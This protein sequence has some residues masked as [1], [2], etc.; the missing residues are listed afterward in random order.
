MTLEPQILHFKLTFGK[1]SQ[2]RAEEQYKYSWRQ[3]HVPVYVDRLVLHDFQPVIFYST[4]LLSLKVVIPCSD[5]S[6]IVRS[7][8]TVGFV[9]G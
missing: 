1:G 9:D 2:L 7:L 4:L 5:I 6:S 3:R 8:C